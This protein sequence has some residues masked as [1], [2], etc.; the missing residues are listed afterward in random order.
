MAS[1]YCHESGWS[2]ASI[3]D[4]GWWD[5]VSFDW[6]ESVVLTVVDLEGCWTATVDCIGAWS[7]DSLLGMSASGCSLVLS[8]LN[9]LTG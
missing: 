5:T 7:T 4:G 1:S 6:T 3:D 9:D 2:T 8:L